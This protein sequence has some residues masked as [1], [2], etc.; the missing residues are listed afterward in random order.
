MQ[1]IKLIAEVGA[2]GKERGG[3]ENEVGEELI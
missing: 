3:G 2:E 1:N